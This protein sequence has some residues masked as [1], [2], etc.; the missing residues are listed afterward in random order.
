[1]SFSALISA[2]L[3]GRVTD[4]IG[5]TKAAVIVADIFAIGGMCSSLV[6][7]C[8][9]IT[10]SVGRLLTIKSSMCFEFGLSIQSIGI[11]HIYI[12][13]WPLTFCQYS[14]YFD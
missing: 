7:G 3:F 1:M 12:Y 4:Y 5:K 14:T 10:F 2:P 13:I 8:S 9:G 6:Y 11:P